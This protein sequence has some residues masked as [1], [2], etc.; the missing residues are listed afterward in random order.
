[1]YYNYIPAHSGGDS[2]VK[3]GGQRMFV[4]VHARMFPCPALCWSL[5]A[6]KF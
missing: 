3:M 6:G 4:G 5:G 2:Y 1:M